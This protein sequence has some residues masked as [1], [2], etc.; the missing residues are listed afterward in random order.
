MLRNAVVGVL[1]QQSRAGQIAQLP[2]Q[3]CF[4]KKII[5]IIIKTLALH[6]K[7]SEENIWIDNQEY[8]A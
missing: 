8:K 7:T 1:H 5:K 2:L 6:L 4:E 3:S